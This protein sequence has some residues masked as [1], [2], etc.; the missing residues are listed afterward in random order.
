MSTVL[1]Y[2]AYD[3]V[4]QC[5]D[6]KEAIERYRAE[7]AAN[8]GAFVTLNELHCGEHWRV[9]VYKSRAEREEYF[10][11]RVRRLIDRF[12]QIALDIQKFK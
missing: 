2:P 11:K 4:E 1:E 3:E 10:R 9:R 12:N 6:D 8:P 5:L 7:K